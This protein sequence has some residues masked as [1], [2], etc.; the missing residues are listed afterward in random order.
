MN[1]R[2]TVQKVSFAGGVLYFVGA[3]Y[4]LLRLES[5]P[6]LLIRDPP[7]ELKGS[8]F[9]KEIPPYMFH[10][11]VAYGS[12]PKLTIHQKNRLDQY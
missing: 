10:L 8:E 7:I 3:G 9:L 2:P 1:S 4:F 5:G 11:L 6:S 12:A